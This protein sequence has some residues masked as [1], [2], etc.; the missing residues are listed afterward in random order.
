MANAYGPN[1][2]YS[3]YVRAG[4]GGDADNQEVKVWGEI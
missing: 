2:K 3:G 4:G 1:A